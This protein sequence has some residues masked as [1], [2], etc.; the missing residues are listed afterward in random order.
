VHSKLDQL[1]LHASKGGSKAAAIQA[2]KQERK[3]VMA[4]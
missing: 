1:I 4:M 2:A 3:I